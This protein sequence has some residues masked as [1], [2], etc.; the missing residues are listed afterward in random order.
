MGNRTGLTGGPGDV[1]RFPA[2]RAPKETGITSRGL[3]TGGDAEAP[4]RTA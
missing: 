1:S 2:A 3:G 4:V